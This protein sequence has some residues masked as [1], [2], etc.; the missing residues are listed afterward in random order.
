MLRDDRDLRRL[1]VG[2]GLFFGKIVV[3]GKIRKIYLN[4]ADM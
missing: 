4:R 3:R 1:R 2:G